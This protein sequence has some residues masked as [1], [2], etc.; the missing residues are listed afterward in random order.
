MR[1]NDAFKGLPGDV[2]SFTMIQELVARA[3]GSEVGRYK[4]FAGSL[5][6][7]DEHHL[8]ARNFIDEGWQ[9]KASMP[10][11]PLGDQ[12]PNLQQLLILEEG[13]RTGSNPKVPPTLPTYWKDLAYLLKIYHA[14]REKASA[15]KVKALRALISNPIFA[16]YIDKRQLQAE[17]R[18]AE[19]PRPTSEPLFGPATD[20]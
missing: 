17:K 19:L 9:S 14:D 15:Q 4:H 5:H 20:E 12:R 10:I 8:K 2:F 16:P 1:S 18:D 7:Y 3:I 13:I 11:M 6:I